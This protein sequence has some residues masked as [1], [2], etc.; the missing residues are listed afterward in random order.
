MIETEDDVID[1]D[2]NALKE[3]IA[4]VESLRGVEH[5]TEEDILILA[6]VTSLDAALGIRSKT[7]KAL[8]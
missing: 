5:C 2:L 7:K 1:N 8:S 6:I 4:V 3:A